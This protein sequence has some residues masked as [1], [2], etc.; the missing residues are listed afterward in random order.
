MH[1]IRLPARE[2]LLDEPVFTTIDD[3]RRSL[4]V[5]EPEAPHEIAFQLWLQF[6]VIERKS[7]R[8]LALPGHDE[9]PEAAQSGNLPVDVEHLRLQEGRAVGSDG[10]F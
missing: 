8:A 4:D 2:D 1:E 5:L 3:G 10:L 7:V 9:C 6:D